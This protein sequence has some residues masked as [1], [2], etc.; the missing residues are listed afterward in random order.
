M[1]ERELDPRLKALYDSNTPVYSISRLGTITNCLAEAK[2]TYI[3]HEKGDGNIYTY[4]GSRTHDALEDI[5]NDRATEK[6]LLPAIREELEDLELFNIEFPKDSRGGDSIKNG[7]IADM[8]HFATT[9]K[10]PKGKN[11]HTEELFIYK[12]PK[13][14]YFQGYIDLYKDNK[15]GTISIF[16]YKTSSMYKGADLKEHGYQLVLYKLGLEQQGKKVKDVAWIFLKYVDITFMGKKTVKSKN[17]TEITKTVERRKIAEEML[18]YVEQDLYEAG[19]DEIDA[20]IML[21]DFKET[22]SFNCFPEDIRDNY[23]VKPCVYKYEVTDEVIQDC[24]EYMDSTIDMWE[25]LDK[26]DESV[27]PPRSFTKTQK[28][29]KVVDDCFYCLCLCNH[30]KTCEYIHDYMD[31]KQNNNEDED[32]F[33]D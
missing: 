10:S 22:N 15:D 12:T 33:G 7:W 30:R 23:V 32:L 21:Q 17:K 28:N 11:L 8:E 1:S 6:D 3:D 19:I 31:S 20:E 14:R 29:G 9:Y 16:D 13:D 24:I 5:V 18:K 27:F 4:L 26:E 25:G 2:K